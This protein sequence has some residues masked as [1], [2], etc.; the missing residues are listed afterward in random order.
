MLSSVSF[1]HPA[2]SI[3]S[4]LRQ[5]ITFFLCIFHAL[6]S[7]LCNSH[8]LHWVVVIG[9]RPVVV[10]KLEEE[11]M[12][13]RKFCIAACRKTSLTKCGTIETERCLMLFSCWWKENCHIRLLTSKLKALAI[14]RYNIC[15]PPVPFLQNLRFNRD[16]PQNRLYF[17][18]DTG[19]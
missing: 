18:C 11:T 16:N 5:E 13:D 2:S 14:F 3:H 8:T 17:L 4:Q 6:V 7:N 19:N 9:N 15:L 10:L 12:H 1:Q